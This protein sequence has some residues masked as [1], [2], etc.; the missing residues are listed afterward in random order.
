MD[1]ALCLANLP[2]DIIRKIIFLS[3]EDIQSS[4]LVYF[5]TFKQA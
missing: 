3:Q 5:C 2:S 1:D 4:R